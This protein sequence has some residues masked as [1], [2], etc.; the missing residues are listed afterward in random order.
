MLGTLGWCFAWTLKNGEDL[1]WSCRLRGQQVEE[2]LTV[3]RVQEEVHDEAGKEH[4]TKSHRL[5]WPGGGI[6]A[7]GQ[8]GF[9]I[10]QEPFGGK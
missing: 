6:K 9:W 2:V 8:R 5:S 3:Y 7:G 4:G 1:R 10:S